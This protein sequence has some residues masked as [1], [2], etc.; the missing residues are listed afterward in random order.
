MFH[1][2]VGDAPESWSPAAG[3]H[4][5]TNSTAPHP[6][7]AAPSLLSGLPPPPAAT[8]DRPEG[9]TA[10]ARPTATCTRLHSGSAADGGSCRISAAAA[11][12]AGIDEA[13]ATPSD[14]LTG[15]TSG[16]GD[17]S[18]QGHQQQP[19]QQGHYRAGRP[20]MHAGD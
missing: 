17:V 14:P 2:P 20:I 11:M 13:W 5:L 8:M 12:A 18:E 3:L 9:P 4:R 16:S 10:A 1:A 15:Q 19:L 7:P 6:S